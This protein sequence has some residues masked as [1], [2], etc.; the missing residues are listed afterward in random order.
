MA[1]YYLPEDSVNDS[2][3][4]AFQMLKDLWW[5]ICTKKGSILAAPITRYGDDGHPDGGETSAEAEFGWNR[6]NFATVNAKLDKI[7]TKLGA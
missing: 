1:N 4:K 6:Q 2:G 5:R 3:Y 7:I